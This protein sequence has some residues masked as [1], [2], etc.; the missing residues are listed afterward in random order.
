MIN[1]ECS[2][3]DGP[4]A[5]YQQRAAEAYYVEKGS[6]VSTWQQFVYTCGSP[7]LN[8]EHLRIESPRVLAYPK[9]VCVYCGRRAFTMDHLEPRGWSGESARAWVAVVP[10]CG[11]CNSLLGATPTTSITERRAI[12]HARLRR[13]FKKVLAYAEYAEEDLEEMGWLL[14]GA[15]ES[16]MAEKEV[17]KAMLEWPE[18]P[19]YDRRA[20]EK[21]GIEDPWGIGFI[22][23]QQDADRV[24]DAVVPRSARS[25]RLVDGSLV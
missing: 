14:R 16:G 4:E 12:C 22:I 7:C 17:V 9:N 25:E 19:F 24:A 8:V 6:G 20:M 10:A 23:S 13:K 1:D 2:K 21:S 18:D 11:A 3:Y 15:V 5:F